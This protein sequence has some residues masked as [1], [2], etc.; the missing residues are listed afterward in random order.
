MKKKNVTSPLAPIPPFEGPLPTAVGIRHRLLVASSAVG[1][2]SPVELVQLGVQPSAYLQEFDSASV[3]WAEIQAF[4][5][6][7][8]GAALAP[9][10]SPCVKVCAIDDKLGLCTGCLRTLDEIAAWGRAG[11][12]ERRAILDSVSRRNVQ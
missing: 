1:Q 2:P 11:D 3:Y 10:A 12:A 6:H 5:R 9:V 4:I 7:N 8:A